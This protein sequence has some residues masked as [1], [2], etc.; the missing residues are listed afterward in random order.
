[1]S[2]LVSTRTVRSRDAFEMFER[3]EDN[4]GGRC[5][6]GQRESRRT[7]IIWDIS[8]TRHLSKID[9]EHHL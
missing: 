1:M 8:V 2:T 5:K 7:R 6:A 3:Y 9:V 4:A